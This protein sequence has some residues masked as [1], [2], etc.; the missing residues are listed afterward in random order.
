MKYLACPGDQLNDLAQ[1]FGPTQRPVPDDPEGPARLI[2][3]LLAGG[4]AAV[5]IIA[6]VFMVAA[7]GTGWLD[8]AARG[9]D[10][11]AAACAAQPSQTEA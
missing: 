9:F 1:P 4:C 3:L 8:K 7:G 5:G 6:T 11:R 2:A 10:E